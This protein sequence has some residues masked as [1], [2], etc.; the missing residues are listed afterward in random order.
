MN[1]KEKR[2]ALFALFGVLS[3]RK[4]ESRS[5]C[6]AACCC[7]VATRSPNFWVCK[8]AAVRAS[9]GSCLKYHLGAAA[10][11]GGRDARGLEL[12][13]SFALRTR[14]MR[15]NPGDHG[16][17]AAAQAM[18]MSKS[19]RRSGSEKSMISDVP[20][21]PSGP[22]TSVPKTSVVAVGPCIAQPIIAGSP[23]AWL[24]LMP[25]PNTSAF[26]RFDTCKETFVVRLTRERTAGVAA[27]SG[28]KAD[29]TFT[30]SPPDPK[31]NRPHGSI[32]VLLSALKVVGTY[33]LS[34][35][36]GSEEIRGSPY[37]IHVVAGP[38]A[39]LRV[40]YAGGFGPSTLADGGESGRTIE[41]RARTIGLEAGET[42]LTLLRAYDRC[43]N[44]LAVG[45]AYLEVQLKDRERMHCAIKDLHD[46]TYEL[47]STC[48]V[49][50]SYPCRVVLLAPPSV[51]AQLA[52]RQKGVPAQEAAAPAI[53]FAL[54]LDLVVSPAVAHAASCRLVGFPARL[55]A[56]EAAL[57]RI[58]SC[59][60]CGNRVHKGGAHWK[61]RLRPLKHTVALASEALDALW[62]G[63]DG[64]GFG[65]GSFEPTLWSAA[66]N[67]DGTYDARLVCERAGHFQ[68]TLEPS[69]SSR[70]GGNGGGGSSAIDVS[71]ASAAGGSQVHVVAL[72]VEP[73]PML[74]SNC[75]L[76]GKGALSAVSGEEAR[77]ILGLR[78]QFGNPTP[79]PSA[80]EVKAR[81]HLTARRVSSSEAARSLVSPAVRS[82]AERAY[83][84]LTRHP[85]SPG[86]DP[87]SPGRD[88]KSPGR[89]P[90][91]PGRDTPQQQQQQQPTT[92]RRVQSAAAVPLSSA[93][94]ISASVISVS[95]GRSLCRVP[96]RSA[97]VP[98]ARRRRLHSP[99]PR[100]STRPRRR[101]SGWEARRLAP[102]GLPVQSLP[103]IV[104]TLCRLSL[105]SIGGH[106]AST[107]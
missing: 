83:G 10:G 16:H 103:L 7:F 2:R 105:W 106:R 104:S 87:K 44:A 100:C 93:S 53:A 69:E 21:R 66:D 12:F 43:G 94:V 58:E 77:A 55:Q 34:I 56:G 4:G 40:R 50:G 70:G 73:G 45:G 8:S 19:A 23:D 63:G 26:M 42:R 33:Y 62:G 59:D 88:P 9:I 76:G 11:T 15:S 97:P 71:D 39:E 14:A 81:L 30:P 89:D 49:A 79:G 98:A 51:E 78:D 29:V 18:A 107:R 72:T 64:R 17:V 28:S 38:P 80:A 74:L 85:K 95:P 92:A 90:K 75:D 48:E 102:L 41:P 65:D 35:V 32:H 47:R 52:M 61:L 84:P 82:A 3:C 31:R 6:D 36:R 54:H 101:A 1:E 37:Q 24:E 13:S 91:S 46:G 27:D 96:C 60:A 22:T 25:A 20:W 86:R 57:F 99:H 67:A 68:C 5:C